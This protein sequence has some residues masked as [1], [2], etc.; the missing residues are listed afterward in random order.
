M[1]KKPQIKASADVI[2]NAL[3]QE[4]ETFLYKNKIH[5]E[6]EVMYK[7]LFDTKRQFRADYVLYKI[8]NGGINELFITVEINGG[9]FIKGRHNRG[10]KGYEK[11]LQKINLAQKN[12]YTVFQYTFEMLKRREY[13]EDFRQII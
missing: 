9:Q 1:I 2:R 4:F 11:D 5:F 7:K 3:L 13:I 12:G 10:G 8:S 6:K